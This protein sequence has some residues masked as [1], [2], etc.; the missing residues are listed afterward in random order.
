MPKV[1]DAYIEIHPDLD[2]FS[3]E[4]RAQMAGL[5]KTVEKEGKKHGQTFGNAFKGG[6]GGSLGQFAAKWATIGAMAGPAMSAINGLAAATVELAAGLVQASAGGAAA[7]GADLGALGQGAI[8]AKIGMTGLGDAF[9]NAAT[10]NKELAAGIKPTDT[11]LKNLRASMQNLAPEARNFVR[12]TMSMSD[13]WD[14]VRRTVQGNIFAG[15]AEP[16]RELGNRY[17]P[18]L[19]DRL[20][21][22]G[23]IINDVAKDMLDWLNQRRTASQFNDIMARHNRILSTLGDAVRPFSDALL[24]LYQA[25]LPLGQKLADAIHRF[26]IWFN[27][28]IQAANQS[29]ALQTFFE[30]A[31]KSASTL[32]RILR[33]LL[34]ALGNIFMAGRTGGQRMLRNIEKLTEKFADWTGTVSGQHALRDWFKEG[35]Q[36][37]R[38]LEGMV[39]DIGQAFGHLA[40]E[41]D[42]SDVMQKL[43][44]GL[45]IVLQIIEDLNQGGTGMGLLTSLEQL[46]STIGSF[47]Y[48]GGATGL[49]GLFKTLN[50][51]LTPLAKIS[52]VVPGFSEL[53]TT[54]LFVGGAAKGVKGFGGAIFG[55]GKDIKDV[56]GAAKTGFTNI[57]AFAQGFRDTQSGMSAFAGPA[58][59]WGSIIRVNASLAWQWA[60]DFSKATV[61]NIKNWVKNAAKA[62]WYG[63]KTAAMWVKDTARAAW[64]MA[65]QGAIILAGWIKAGAQ[66]VWYGIKTAALWVAEKVRAAAG[67][68]V[69]V[70][71]VVAGWIAAGAGAIAYGAQVA[72]MWVAQKVITLIN[73]AISVATVIGGWIAMAAAA[74]ANAAVMAVAWLIALG[75]IGLII[76]AVVAVIAILVLLWKKCSWFRDAVKAIWAWIKKNTVATFHAIGDVFTWLW[77][78]VIVPVWEGIKR[79]ISNAWNWIKR[80]VMEAIHKAINGLGDVFKW[81]WHHVVQPVWEGIKSAINR[82]WE[83]IK[84]IFGWLV[85]R[86]NWVKTQFGRIKDGIVRVFN[87]LKSAISTIFDKIKSVVAVPIRWVINTV[88]NNGII[89]AVNDIVGVIPAIKWRIPKIPVGFGEGGYTGRGPRNRVAGAVHADEYVLRSEARRRFERTHPGW[90]DRLNRTGRLPGYKRGG[91]VMPVRGVGPVSTGDE[92]VDFPVGMFTPVFAA[93]RGLVKTVQYLTTSYGHYVILDHGGG[94]SSY[95]GHLDRILVHPGQNVDTGQQIATSDDTGHSTGPHLHFEVRRNGVYIT[96]A[97]SRSQTL[98]F[99]SGAGVA[100]GAIASGGPAGRPKPPFLT[101]PIGWLKDHIPQLFKNPGNAWE[102]MLYGIPRYGVEK[103]AD[104]INALG[105]I[106]RWFTSAVSWVAGKLG[107]SSNTPIPDMARQA[108]ARMGWLPMWP[109]LDFI[110]SHESSWNPRATNPSSGAYGLFQALPPSKMASAGAD[111]RTNPLTQIRWGMSYIKSRYGNPSAARM[112]WEQHGW[113]D[114]GGYLPTGLSM[115]MNNTGRPEP[116]LTDT[117]LRALTDHAE[118]RNRPQVGRLTITNWQQGTGYFEI[119]AGNVVDDRARFAHDVGTMRHA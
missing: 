45:D 91:V 78:K 69:T 57:R 34:I 62:T 114:N 5:G 30:D 36:V 15:L 85:D 94:I 89:R 1:G 38:V 4:M 7:L 68:A 44:D 65:K 42:P 58:Q 108:L 112:F 101:D 75:P 28:A 24:T 111:W 17:I 93:L 16:M 95:Y 46:A 113:Y 105:A 13:E 118:R 83:G 73:M 53:M 20:G 76:I 51:L 61:T 81:F 40:G 82:E 72:A 10:V 106:K 110:V 33:N 12:T 117:Q 103:I 43:R 116:V 79:A 87:G 22:T 27:N 49:T 107:I 99:L 96:G 23:T 97:A 14:K 74:M 100:K 48:V 56:G 63:I 109:D 54:F 37:F 29:G 98:G 77:K 90:L 18:I 3:T 35:R 9:K 21:D 59:R 80:H 115:V 64:A 39:G 102:R 11:E 60:K 6:V 32:G 70:A 92:G 8:A 2:K 67:M 25:A 104:A 88:L 19:N 84:R 71:V 86:F 47:G 31:W 119:V 52:Q 50:L 41:M 66:A 26:A 55:L